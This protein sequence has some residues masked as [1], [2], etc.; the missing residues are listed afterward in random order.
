MR[1]HH[2]AEAWLPPVLV[3]ALLHLVK[4]DLAQ[5]DYLAAGES[6]AEL[7]NADGRPAPSNDRNKA[8]PRQAETNSL[9]E[10]GTRLEPD[11]SSIG[12]SRAASSVSPDVVE[13]QQQQGLKHSDARNIMLAQDR[14]KDW[15]HEECPRWAESSQVC[16]S[17]GRLFGSICE[18]RRFSCLHNMHLMAKPKAYCLD[19]AKSDSEVRVVELRRAC[20]RAEYERMKLLLVADFNGDLVSMFNYLDSNSNGLVEAH[21]LWPKTSEEEKRSQIY[22]QLWSNHLVNCSQVA[23]Q[24]YHFLQDHSK[25]W[26]FLDFAFEPQYPPNPCSL[27]HLMLFEAPDLASRR[28]LAGSAGLALDTFKRAFAKAVASSARRRPQHGPGWQIR[29]PVSAPLGASL[30]LS[31]LDKLASANELELDLSEVS[32]KPKCQWTRYGS[33]LATLKDPHLVHSSD[34][35]VLHLRDAQLYLSGPYKCECR[36]DMR[37][38]QVLERIFEVQVVGKL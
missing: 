4:F 24:A 37:S 12:K 27:S 10:S 38:A 36:L 30:S 15:C 9:I 22:A 20:N 1:V 29:T 8:S 21:E 18:L 14:D 3:L 23:S 33:S 16:A 2:I 34:L 31:C 7:R 17:N 26:F 28:A 11:R 5:G 19:S 35:S 25:C 6:S 32:G 13:Q